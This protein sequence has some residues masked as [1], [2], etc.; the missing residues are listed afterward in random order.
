[1]SAEGTETVTIRAEVPAVVLELV[2]G[3]LAGGAGVVEY[4][5]EFEGLD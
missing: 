2:P 5:A 1:M 3:A 4:P